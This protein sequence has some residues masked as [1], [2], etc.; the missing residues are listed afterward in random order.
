MVKA[1]IADFAT[2]KG[3]RVKVG[4]LGVYNVLQDLRVQLYKF[5]FQ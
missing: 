2:I 1:P 3:K 5:L 4:Y